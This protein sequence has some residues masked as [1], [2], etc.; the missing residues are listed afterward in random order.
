MSPR[1]TIRDF[2]I[3]I[4]LKLTYK[5]HLKHTTPD[6][7]DICSLCHATVPPGTVYFADL[8]YRELLM[9]IVTP[10]YVLKTV[11]YVYLKYC[12]PCSR[13][14]FPGCYKRG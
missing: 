10:N 14:V 8:R 4:G 3:G 12:I 9:P 13:S 2:A 11:P 7:G 1:L 5:K 6:T